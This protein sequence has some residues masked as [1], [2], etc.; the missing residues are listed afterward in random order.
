M[1][2]SLRKHQIPS[3]KTGKGTSAIG[4]YPGVRSSSQDF[5]DKYKFSLTKQAAEKRGLSTIFSPTLPIKSLV[6]LTRK[7][8]RKKSTNGTANKKLL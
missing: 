3:E 4:Y 1:A 6:V 2:L 8:S 5:K 7:N